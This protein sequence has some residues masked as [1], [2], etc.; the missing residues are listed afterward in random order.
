M[1]LLL[2][3]LII[4]IFITLPMPWSQKWSQLKRQ[5][6]TIEKSIAQKLINSMDTEWDKKIAQVA[7]EMHLHIWYES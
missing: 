6:R 3:S 1:K 2:F 7:V 5:V 4:L